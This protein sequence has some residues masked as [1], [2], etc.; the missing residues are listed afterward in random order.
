MP[1]V[2][3]EL[4]ISPEDKVL[5]FRGQNGNQ[6]TIVYVEPDA[7]GIP[8]TMSTPSIKKYNRHNHRSIETYYER[9]CAILEKEIEE[10]DKMIVSEAFR[11][12]RVIF[13]YPKYSFMDRIRIFFG[14]SP[15]RK[16]IGINDCYR[17]MES[18][19]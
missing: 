11:K 18:L 5:V 2:K 12:S 3:K 1:R 6:D 13:R 8:R 14:K 7:C 19:S 17:E 10:R 9:R 16:N 4:V 15:K